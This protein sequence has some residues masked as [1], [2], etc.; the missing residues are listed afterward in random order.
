MLWPAAPSNA[1]L[2]R[3]VPDD[4]FLISYSPATDSF[5]FADDYSL[6]IIRAVIDARFDNLALE[7]LEAGGMGPETSTQLRA[8]RDVLYEI[9]DRVDWAALSEN[10]TVFA[11]KTGGLSP[12]V[13]VLPMGTLL[14]FNPD[15][16]AAPKLEQALRN[17]FST[18]ALIAPDSLSF[19]KRTRDDTRIYS[20]HVGPFAD[21]ALAQLAVH[22]NEFMFVFGHGFLEGA[23][24]RLEGTS[25]V[26]LAETERYTAAF[27]D[28]PRDAARTTFV[29]VHGALSDAKEAILPYLGSQDRQP[30]ED[31][32]DLLDVVDTV[33]L[34]EHAKDYEVVT[35]QR[36]RYRDE[37]VD[38]R[39]P[40]YVAM[41]ESDENSLLDFVPAEAT[42][43]T[44]TSGVNLVPMY[45]WVIER[46]QIYGDPELEVEANLA[47]W[48]TIQAVLDLSF[49][50]DLLAIADSNTVVFSMPAAYPTPLQP[51]DYVYMIELK[52]PAGAR[53]LIR[54]LENVYEAGLPLLIQ[55][56]G[57]SGELPNLE[58]RD[59]KGI[60]PGMK[61]VNMTIQAPGFAIPMPQFTYGI[62]GNKLIFTNSQETLA[63]SMEAAAEEV[64]G[65]DENA[66]IK[67]SGGLPR[68]SMVSASLTPYA[69]R[70]ASMQ[71]AVQIM[72][73]S[74]NMV[75]S[76]AGQVLTQRDAAGEKNSAA[77]MVR[78]ASGLLPRFSAIVQHYDFLR[79]GVSYAQR[80]E[81]GRVRYSRTTTRYFEPHERPT[82]SGQ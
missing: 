63:L 41:F 36:I 14:A 30:L 31:V 21:Q 74:M 8:L 66:T 17:L 44:L 50:E 40:L 43:F 26:S 23:L 70:Y 28:L 1:Q 15:L 16:E 80:L 33:A 46:I 25:G 32:I 11:M 13:P 39:N 2:I 4:A 55:Y 29:D 69:E 65:I 35:Q 61:H 37:A 19:K 60:F 48:R 81:S 59:A 27:G 22:E 72:V 64:D 77:A 68:D 79:S 71:G 12:W 7:A 52:N 67:A 57:G 45:H 18:V 76:T 5:D 34:V 53:K 38:A 20:L 58:I 3:V 56:S 10:E 54:R 49:E 47:G 62:V 75:L 82:F 9:I 51:E 42:G 73:T 24:A 78:Y 6:E